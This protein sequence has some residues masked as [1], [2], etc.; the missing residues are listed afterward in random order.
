MR[1]EGKKFSRG[2]IVEA[3]FRDWQRDVG[4]PVFIYACVCDCE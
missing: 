2:N 4:T 3:F 1:D